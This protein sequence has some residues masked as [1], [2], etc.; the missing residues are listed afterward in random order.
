MASL[1]LP[2]PVH[3]YAGENELRNK[4][5][6]AT[7]EDAE[8][9]GEYRP[10]RLSD[11]LVRGIIYPA[12]D[13]RSERSDG[14]MLTAEIIDKTA[15]A[16]A[17]TAKPRDL[18]DRIRES[19]KTDPR[20][21]FLDEED[22]Y[23]PYYKWRVAKSQEELDDMAKG[24]LPTNGG[25]PGGSVA[26]AP[27]VAEEPF[28]PGYEP[29]TWD[30]KVDL[31]GVTA[32][33]LDVLRLTALFHARRGRSFLEA[34]SRKEGRNYQFD[35]LRPT[36]SLYGYY[37]R[38]VESYQKI[39]RPPP[40]QVEA[41]LKADADPKAKWKTLDE[42]RL[43]AQW[44]MGRRK[45]LAAEDLE[46]DEEAKAFAEIDWQDFVTVE[47]IE[48]TQADMELQ[49]PPPTSIDK[50]HEMSMAERRMA[51]MLM[52]EPV[53]APAPP[54]KAAPA[55]ASGDVEEV[56]MEED[57]ED[58]E[59]RM[60]R[61]REEQELARAREV[62]RAAMESKG[63]RIKKDHKRKD[64]QRGGHVATS[65]CPYCG[66]SIPESELSEHIR[67]ELLDPRW[68][69]QRRQLEARRQQAQQLQV[70]ADP[71]ASLRNLASARTDI[72]GDEEDEA[73]RRKREEEEAIKSK[74]RLNLVW[75][76]HTATA[77]QTKDTFKAKF[78]AEDQRRRAQ[79]AA[80]I[81]DSPV[82][83]VGPQVGPGIKAAKP[84]AAQMNPARA[85][86]MRSAP[87]GA[88]EAPRPAK[89]ARVDKLPGGQLYSEIDWLSLH[90]HPVAVSIQLPSMA[91]K[92]EWKL[93]GS[94]IAVPDVP[95]NT[96]FG[97]LR[98]RIKRAVDADLPISR[99]KLDFNGKVMNNAASLASV[100]LDE[101]D[102]VVMS[103]RK[104]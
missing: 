93:D 22:P 5:N 41:I 52:E 59:S 24:I 100:N 54:P 92:P 70:G 67:I 37:N 103:V 73:T 9:M 76:G 45:R 32:A 55:A 60:E 65:K 88:A 39:M 61:I 11:K 104:K 62:Q 86:M 10:P 1:N 20:F 15:L 18:E 58:D 101:G 87:D 23:Y 36:H 13:V 89:R 38:M 51:A 72:F 17:K 46:R 81:T 63:I 19:Q 40:G 79:E 25:T 31:P 28:M 21:V 64:I 97:Q 74:E 56:D 33:D 26:P 43:R 16:V 6:G 99:L 42:A 71:T 48:F 78:S 3:S 80:G 7:V 96:T 35:F 27:V 57:E 14:A 94:V 85:A 77:A 53:A 91:D 98:E 50:L 30:F 84:A 66:E 34:L 75:D 95:V 102:V 90:P 2:K 44:E 8:D 68:R 29:K 4:P 82:N 69:E 49:L 12:P 83:T 47:T